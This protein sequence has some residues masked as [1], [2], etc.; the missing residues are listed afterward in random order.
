MSTAKY[1]TDLGE[2][3]VRQSYFRVLTMLNLSKLM[4]DIVIV[5]L[6]HMAIVLSLHALLA[7]GNKKFSFQN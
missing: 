3:T 1:Q 6:I 5:L 4:W 7:S 2:N